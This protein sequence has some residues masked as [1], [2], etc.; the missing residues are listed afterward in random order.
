MNTLVTPRES[1]LDAVALNKTKHLSKLLYDPMT[2]PPAASTICYLCAQP[3][4]EPTDVDHV[5]AKCFFAPSIRRALNLSQLITIRVH[6]HCN[7]SFRLD[8]EYF[9]YSLVPLALGSTA[10]NEAYKRIREKFRRM[11][12]RPLVMQILKEFEP[13]PGGLALPG[14]KV[15]KRFDPNRI[16]RVIWKI[17]RG[18]FFR[19]HG[20]TLPEKLELTWT[21][22]GPDDG[23]PPQLFQIFD[24]NHPSYGDY[25]GVFAYQFDA[26]PEVTP[27]GHYWALMFWDK[28]IVTVAFAH[29]V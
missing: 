7:H 28:I 11:K 19:H 15:L 9:L 6:R 29:T 14:G 16:E 20:K 17:V 18:L 10:A 25:P 5:P 27:N 13:R 21:F 22:T 1:K 23:P 8:E 24:S 2:D 4:V 12:N 3:L 26:Y